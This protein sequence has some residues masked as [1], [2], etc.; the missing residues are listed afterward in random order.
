MLKNRYIRINFNLM[1]LI[2]YTPCKDIDSYVRINQCFARLGTCALALKLDNYI[3]IGRGSGMWY[4]T[5]EK[6]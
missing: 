2:R 1:G 4:A 6:Y 5:L 3:T